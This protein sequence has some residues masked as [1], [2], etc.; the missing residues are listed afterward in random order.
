MP[1]LRNVP[2]GTSA[3]VISAAALAERVADRLL[4]VASAAVA[5]ELEVPVR[6]RARPPGPVRSEHDLEPMA[7]RQLVHAGPD[8]L[9]VGHVPE[10]QEVGDGRPVDLSSESRDRAS[11]PSAPRRTRSRA[12]AR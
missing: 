3:T 5:R 12:G 11:A 10:R 8:G 7:G 9:G 2:I 1:P 6:R 4:P